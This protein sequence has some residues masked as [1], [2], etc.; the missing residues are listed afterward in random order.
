VAIARQ[1]GN[2]VPV[3][4]AQAVGELVLD[5]LIAGIPVDE[6][7]QIEVQAR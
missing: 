4:L 2:A 3:P 1:I 7:P 6:L 5:G